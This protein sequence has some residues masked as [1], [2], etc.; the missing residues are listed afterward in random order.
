MNVITNTRASG[1]ALC[2]R[3]DY[4]RFVYNGGE[5]IEPRYF[6]RPIAR[7]LAGHAALEAY[8]NE[9]KD[10]SNLDTCKKAMLDVVDKIIINDTIERPAE[11][12][13]INML[14]YL[15]KLL[16]WYAEYYQT[17]PFRIVEVEK[18]FTTPVDEDI[19]YAMKLDL[20]IEFTKGEF[21]GDLAVYDHKFVYNFK[22]P[23]EVD[24]DSQLPKYIKTLRENGYYVTK[25]FFNQI[26][27][28]ELK[29][30]EPTD[31]FKRT[32]LKTK[33][34]KTERIWSEQREY[35]KKI[36][37]TQSDPNYD[38]LRTLSVITC[39]GCFFQP[40]CH[41]ELAGEDPTE[42]IN[43]NFQKNTYGY[44]DLFGEE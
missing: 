29:N 12:E 28:R 38:P 9:M 24:M 39:R 42:M 35:A 31:I 7:G 22:T 34:V 10:G 40:V 33:S 30:P 15:R 16:I 3:S 8:Y 11:F 21:R 44:T 4:Y 19:E 23:A 43:S 2:E 17:E 27:H 1:F 20:L 36:V 32:P 13:H 18:V 37:K 5:G 14:H 6:S 26:R 25:G 41:L